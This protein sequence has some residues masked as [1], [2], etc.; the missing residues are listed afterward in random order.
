MSMLLDIQACHA[1]G[2]RGIWINR[3]GHQGNPD[4]LPDAELPDLRGVP[5]LL[6]LP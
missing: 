4:W 5:A 6:G 1:L 3:F 2:M